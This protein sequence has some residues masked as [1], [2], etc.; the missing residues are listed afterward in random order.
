MEPLH[1]PLQVGE[2]VVTFAVIAVGC[3]ITK[4]RE[5]VQLLASVTVTV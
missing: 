3:V 2:T 5:A 4:L 1:T